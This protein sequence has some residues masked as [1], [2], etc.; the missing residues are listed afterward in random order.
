MSFPQA[1]EL[2]RLADEKRA[3]YCFCS[4]PRFLRRRPRQC[5]GHFGKKRSAGSMRP[6]PKWMA[7]L[8]FAPRDRDLWVNELG[9]PWPFKDEF[10]VGCTDRAC[11]LSGILADDFFWASG[12]E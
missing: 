11:G 7:V 2:V 1:Q 6:T 10:A 4:L 3:S 5:G 9:M 8:S 12:H